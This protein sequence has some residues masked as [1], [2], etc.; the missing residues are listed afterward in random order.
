MTE[1]EPDLGWGLIR[2]QLIG[3]RWLVRWVFDQD[4]NALLLKAYSL[5]TRQDDTLL[6]LPVGGSTKSQFGI[7]DLSANP[8]QSLLAVHGGPDGPI[9]FDL[10]TGESFKALLPEPV[11]GNWRL[12]GFNWVD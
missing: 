10:H 8:A 12:G 5:Q 3:G 2:D 6:T 7:L 11:L 9:V 4:A 1:L